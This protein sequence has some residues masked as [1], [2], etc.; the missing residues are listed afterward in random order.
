L[1]GKLKD[2][3]RSRPGGVIFLLEVRVIYAKSGPMVIYNAQ[4]TVEQILCALV[5]PYLI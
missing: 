2:N 5:N 1:E 3:G 4:K